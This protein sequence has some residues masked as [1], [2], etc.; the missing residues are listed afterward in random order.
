MF[1]YN[2]LHTLKTITICSQIIFC[3]CSRY[4][5]DRSFMDDSLRA[6]GTKEEVVRIEISCVCAQ[7]RLGPSDVG[8]VCVAGHESR[9]GLL[10]VSQ[11][12]RACHTC[13]L[14]NTA[15]QRCLAEAEH[16]RTLICQ[17]CRISRNEVLRL[18]TYARIFGSVALISFS[19]ECLHHMS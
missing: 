2:L 19:Y 14:A 15:H 8:N 10:L 17:P 4:V 9:L 7:Q 6:G 18:A 3:H 13:Q 1:F 16:S 12:P 5:M 11:L